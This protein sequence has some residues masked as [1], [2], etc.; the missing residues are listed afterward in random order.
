MWLNS[1]SLA[2]NVAKTKSVLFSK[3]K[4]PCIDL[5]IESQ[6]IEAVSCVKF[7]GFY[8]DTN[9]SGEHHIYNLYE[10][11]LNSVYVMHKIGSFVPQSCLLT[12]YNAHFFSRLNYGINKWFPLLRSYDKDQLL[13]LQKCIVRIVNKK[14]FCEHCMPLFKCSNILTISDMVKIENLKLM[15]RVTNGSVPKPVG[16]LFTKTSHK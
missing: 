8:L 11:L 3:L 5:K 6:S 16:N 15:Y 10:S 13:K 12:L 1:N 9:L 14:S 7:L 2:L 4:M